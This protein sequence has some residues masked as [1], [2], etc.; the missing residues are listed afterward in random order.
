VTP[1]SPGY[2][3][4][5]VR[6]YGADPT[7]LADSTA[8]VQ[9]ALNARQH[10][11][12]PAGT[13]LITS[14]LSNA[15]AGRRVYGDGPQTSIL[16]PVG[17]I[18]TLIN[19]APLNIVTMDNFGISGDSS[20]LDGI[21]QAAGTTLASS[22]F[23]NIFVTVGGRAF[24]LFEEFSTQLVNCNAS[25]YNNNVFELQGGNTTRLAGCYAVQV[26]AGYY[27]YRLYGGGQL[28]SCNGIDS[29]NGGDWGLFG[30]V[31]SKGDPAT[32]AYYVSMTN[33]NI[34][35]FDNYGVRLRGTGYAK[36]SGGS[37]QA[38]ATGT[39]QAELYVEYS[40]NL[41][42]VEN[43]MVVSKGAA[44]ARK[45]AIFM[46]GNSNIF[47]VGNNFDPHYEVDGTLYSLPQIVSTYPG[48]LQRAV[49]INNLDVSQ[50]YNRYSGTAVLAGGSASVTFRVSQWDANYHVL[51]SGNAAEIF[52]VLNKTTGGFVI[53]SSNP[54]STASVDWMVVRT[55]T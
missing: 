48:Y 36:L 45:A 51:V 16:K 1:V 3:P 2:A 40:N 13:Y 15:V 28:D 26:P 54:A 42:I 34:E 35:D 11:Y 52:Q 17:P 31:A 8:A 43:V 14:P 21:T 44:R 27:G 4:G 55:G 18:S 23:E 22:V 10:V 6:R 29:P 37:F 41:V 12:I 33:C 20:T 46:S 30:A 39:Y 50:L 5:D 9:T 19:S 24:Y 25:S 49:C 53:A 7:G 47:V 38:K 32:M